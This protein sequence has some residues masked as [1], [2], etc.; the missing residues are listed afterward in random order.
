MGWRELLAEIFPVDYDVY[1]QSDRWKLK[2]DACKKRAGYR[3]QLCGATKR[4]EAH[5]NTYDRLGYEHKND[6]VCLCHK[7]H[8]GYHRWKNRQ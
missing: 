2:A 7:C 5:H 1:I 4:L 6:L 3:C 8:F